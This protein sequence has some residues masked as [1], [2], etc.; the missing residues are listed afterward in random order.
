M[1]SLGYFSEA[2]DKYIITT[3]MTST[4]WDNYLFNKN[5]FMKVLQTAQGCI[6]CEG[7]VLV[8]Y[9]ADYRHYK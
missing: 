8:E 6:R 5:Y 1:S 4:N 7:P 2:G 9:T 3:P